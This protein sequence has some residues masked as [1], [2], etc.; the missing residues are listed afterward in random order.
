MGSNEGLN[1]WD[2]SLLSLGWVN[3]LFTSSSSSLMGL[4]GGGCG[5]TR[6]SAS[7]SKAALTD[8]LSLL[9]RTNFFRLDRPLMVPWWCSSWYEA[10]SMRFY[11]NIATSIVT[12]TYSLGWRRRRPARPPFHNAAWCDAHF[13]EDTVTSI[14]VVLLLPLLRLLLLKLQ[15]L[16]RWRRRLSMATVSVKA[17]PFPPSK[18]P[19]W[20]R[21]GGC[22]RST[23]LASTASVMRT[24]HISTFISLLQIIIADSKLSWKYCCFSLT[25]VDFWNKKF[26]GKYEI[27]FK[28]D[29]N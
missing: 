10:S 3:S 18:M 6:S 23:T 8:S 11:T 19:R 2:L 5:S 7:C 1:D 17:R 4:S 14:M 15:P 12:T 16:P 29:F 20:S 25:C 26:F 9:E 24:Q 22:R 27:H 21:G 13:E 28:T